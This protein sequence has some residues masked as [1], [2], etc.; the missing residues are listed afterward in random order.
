MICAPLEKRSWNVKLEIG[1]ESNLFQLRD[2]A[3]DE[4]H[5][6]ITKF[7]YGFAGEEKIVTS[8]FAKLRAGICGSIGLLVICWGNRVVQYPDDSLEVL[9]RVY[10]S[11][12]LA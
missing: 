5:G 6:K 10:G 2:R 3:D 9:L 11:S 8:S 12:N 1:T 4:T 7:Q